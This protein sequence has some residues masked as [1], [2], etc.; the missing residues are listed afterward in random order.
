MV[1]MPATIRQTLLNGRQGVMPA[2]QNRL[3]DADIRML[4]LYVEGL[5]KGSGD[6]Q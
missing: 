5:S 2:W 1:A 4:A 6:A 3:S